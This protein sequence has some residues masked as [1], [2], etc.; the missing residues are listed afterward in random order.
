[1]RVQRGR[2]EVKI[3][4]T[5]PREDRRLLS[6]FDE[7]R[8]R[9]EDG[10][11]RPITE[12]A[13][14]DIVRSYS[15]INRIDQSRSI[16]VSSDLDENVANANEV[17][18]DLKAIFLPNLLRDFPGVRVRWEGQQEQ[19]DES[20]N[21]LFSGFIVALVA[22]FLLLAIEFKSAIQPALV[23][24]IIPFGI[25]GAV[26]GHIVMG[27][28]LTLFSMY[29]LVAL[30]G[31]VVNDSIVLIDFINSRVRAG[32]PIDVALHESGVRRFRPVFLTTVTTVGGLVPIL[33]ETSVQAQI[34]IPMATSIAFG[35]A[36]S[37]AIVL[38]L[39]PV[40]YSIYWSAGG[41]LGVDSDIRELLITEPEPELAIASGPRL[42]LDAN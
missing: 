28:P 27:I 8:V 36:L 15:E 10:V 1:M 38:Y 16:T 24:S 34:L 31:I 6:N 17:I 41:R 21:S 7:I 26:L 42:G 3:M 2:H 12:L 11:E 30:T 18:T 39:V 9:M 35:Q 23:M 4:V 37:T 22:M 14:I 32:V 33:L 40:S 29:G 25:F 19:R 13:E 20:L 5:Y